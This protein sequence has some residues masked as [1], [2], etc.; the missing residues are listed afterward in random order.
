MKR[1]C[2]I[3]AL[4][5]GGLTTTA[6]AQTAQT[7]KFWNLTSETI[8]ELK[9]AEPGTNKWGKNQTLNDND[10]TVEADERQ[11]GEAV[12]HRLGVPAEAERAVDD[13][14]AGP[15]DRRGEQL[16]AAL[17]HHGDVQFCGVHVFPIGQ[18]ACRD[19][20]PS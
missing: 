17:E 12:E 18:A 20:H 7:L 6:H 14:G 16:D 2:L 19:P 5:A 10:K 13:D 4:C 8:T 1:Y 15:T 9:L 3:L 11:L